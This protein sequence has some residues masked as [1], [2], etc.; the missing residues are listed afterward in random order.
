METYLFDILCLLQEQGRIQDM[1]YPI[2]LTLRQEKENRLDYNPQG[3]DVV[4]QKKGKN[5]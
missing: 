1:L 5:Y 2:I 4:I 3:T